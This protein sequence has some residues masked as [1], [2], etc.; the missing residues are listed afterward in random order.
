MHTRST[1]YRLT[2]CQGKRHV[3]AEH[4]PLTSWHDSTIIDFGQKIQGFREMT[5]WQDVTL[6][7]CKDTIYIQRTGGFATVGILLAELRGLSGDASAGLTH[8]VADG[9]FEDIWP[10]AKA[11]ASVHSP[12]LSRT[13]AVQKQR[14]YWDRT[15]K[16][17]KMSFRACKKK[18]KKKGGKGWKDFPV[19]LITR[20]CYCCFVLAF[21]GILIWPE[22]PNLK[23]HCSMQREPSALQ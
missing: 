18:K 8:L 11:T 22:D 2:N 21:L 5:R 1:F 15:P 10:S 6:T 16:A 9:W 14:F 12:Q 7:K 20:P 17:I 13:T 19:L 4:L 23:L 3:Y